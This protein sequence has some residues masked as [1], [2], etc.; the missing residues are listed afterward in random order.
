[1]T[2]N[3][4]TNLKLFITILFFL[5][6]LLQVLPFG[7]DLGWASSCFA[8]GGIRIEARNIVLKPAI[9]IVI[10][11]TGNWTNN[12]TATCNTGSWVRMSGNAIQ[13]IQGTNTT[14]F[15]NL[16]INTTSSVFVQRDITIN[17]ALNLTKGYFDLRGA[18][19]YLGNTSGNITGGETETKRIRATTNAGGTDDGAGVGTIQTTRANP[20]GTNV[21]NLGLIFTP[22]V[23]LGTTTIIR[24][25]LR[26]QGTGSFTGNYSVFRYYIIQPTVQSNVTVNNFYYF[27]AELGTQAANEATLQMFQWV[28]FGTPQWWMPRTTTGADMV[29][30]YVA[31]TTTTNG[32]STYKITLG[33]TTSPLPIE[34]VSFTANCL[35]PFGGGAGGGV[36]VNWQTASETNNDYFVL[37]RLDSLPS[38][39]LGW[40]SIATITGA[41]NSNTLLNYSY[42]DNLS[43]SN[44]PSLWEGVGGWAYYR[45]KQVDYD[46][47]FT[48]SDT[49]HV[50]CQEHDI[51]IINIYPNPA[52]NYFNYTIC[53]TEDREIFVSVIDVL[54]RTLIRKQEYVNAGIN[55]CSLDV[56]TLASEVYYFK[57]ETLDGL[58]KDSKQILI[59]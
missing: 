54:G 47:N 42:T 51:E 7:K 52:Q 21:A 22:S 25:H 36:S 10:T 45:L 55:H 30:N 39:G 19:T 57:I 40:A 53:S 46:G 50:N 58:S 29:T 8:Q 2:N 35:S 18:I 3:L 12:G 20:S 24:G 23:A 48:Y 34:I 37:E 31:S 56:S 43:T 38:G 33:S 9:Y 1:M 41:G 59:K 15:S 49:I 26:Q 4:I 14:A 6:S 5:P 16:D 13:N 44:S 27:H 32:L 17:D 28:Q 11:G